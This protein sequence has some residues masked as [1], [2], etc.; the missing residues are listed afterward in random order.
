MP[1]DVASRE[2]V[3][4]V[5]N[6]VIRKFGRLD[7]SV[8]CADMCLAIPEHEIIYATALTNVMYIARASV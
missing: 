5:V 4:P 7:H 2:S 8:S 6:A 1:V 3:Q